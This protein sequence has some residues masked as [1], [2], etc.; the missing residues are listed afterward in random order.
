MCG[1]LRSANIG[2]LGQI[3]MRRRVLFIKLSSRM[4]RKAH[5]SLVWIRKIFERQRRKGFHAHLEQP[6]TSKMLKQL[7]ILR[8]LRPMEGAPPV[9]VARLAQ[10]SVGLKHPVTKVPILKL[11]S[12]VTTDQGMYEAMNRECSHDRDRHVLEGT[13]KTAQG[14][15]PLTRWVEGYPEGLSRKVAKVIIPTKLCRQRWSKA[16]PV[17]RCKFQGSKAFPATNR[18]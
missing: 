13:V 15:Q 2:R 10:C 3:L 12:I 17:V 16:F 14:Y 18:I 11:T 5:A 6:V 4:R 1:V 7:E 8:V 9:Q